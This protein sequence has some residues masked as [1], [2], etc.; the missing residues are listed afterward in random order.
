MKMIAVTVVAVLAALAAA[1]FAWQRNQAL[2]QVKSELASAS[3][4]LQKARNEL[5]ALKAEA[6]ALRKEAAEQK[7]ATDQLR[8]EL[9]SARAFLDSERLTGARLREELVKAKEQL[10]AMGK[11]R[12]VQ[13]APPPMAVPMMV[14]PPPA[15]V[16]PGQRGTA[17]GVGVP[18]K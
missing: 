12:S 3:A 9:N 15:A 8:T 17:I 13:S 14:R 4:D 1:G 11:A 18:A 7:S 16:A 5:Q 2:G 10:A 6:V